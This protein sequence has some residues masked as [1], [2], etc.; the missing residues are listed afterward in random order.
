M[1]LRRRST[2]S[3]PASGP[4]T[5]R[6][7]TTRYHLHLLQEDLLRSASRRSCDASSNRSFSSSPIVSST[8]AWWVDPCSAFPTA[9]AST[10]TSS[11]SSSSSSSPQH[12]SCSEKTDLK[13][14]AGSDQWTTQ[15][16]LASLQGNYTSSQHL[17]ASIAALVA[18]DLPPAQKRQ[19]AFARSLRDI[20]LSD[21]EF[22]GIIDFDE[23]GEGQASSSSSSSRTDR[24]H[25]LEE[26]TDEPDHTSRAV[27]P[28]HPPL[29]ETRRRRWT[30]YQ[31]CALWQAF[32]Q[33]GLLDRELGSRIYARLFADLRNQKKKMD[34][35]TA[36]RLE[37]EK[38]LRRDGIRVPRFTRGD[39]EEVVEDGRRGDLVDDECTSSAASTSSSSRE[40]QNG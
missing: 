39:E 12:H 15:Q 3:L 30:V 18:A 17:V 35:K 7:G 40:H 27:E 5:I 36:K 11:C 1:P 19:N 10:S 23:Q 22:S 4:H 37:D 14:V 32:A 25:D 9:A 24:K 28:D 20:F 29:F 8:T 13:N 34:Q 6:T 2:I 33:L 26:H 16:L 31:V 38:K 21:L